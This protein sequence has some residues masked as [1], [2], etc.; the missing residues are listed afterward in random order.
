MIHDVNVRYTSRTE[1][2]P[3]LSSDTPMLYTIAIRRKKMS[4]EEVIEKYF[5]LIETDRFSKYEKDF[6]HKMQM[7]LYEGYQREAYEPEMVSDVQAIINNVNGFSASANGFRISTN[8]IFIH[9]NKSQ[10]EFEYYGSKTQRE[11]GDLIFITSVIYNNRKY[12]EKLTITQ[13]KRST[14]RPKWYFNKKDKNGKYPDKEQVY[15]LARF[16][17]FKGTKGSII[18]M[19]EYSLP[20]YS[21]CL[22]SYG[23]LYKPGDFAFASAKIVE[24]FLGNSKNISIEHILPSTDFYESLMFCPHPLFR[25]RDAKE[26]FYIGHKLCR[27]YFIKPFFPYLIFQNNFLPCIGNSSHSCNVHEFSER[28]LRALIGELTFAYEFSYN[29]PAFQF[30][31]DLMMAIKK[32]AQ[33]E[34]NDKIQNFVD[35]FYLH[36]YGE[37][38]RGE[39]FGEFD[40]EGGGIGVIH[41]SINLGKGE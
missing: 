26:L 20:N 41:T 18:P 40:Y 10:I 31:Q 23:L 17:T 12:F 4:T 8:S 9:G 28:Y 11:L 32:K 6:A 38:Q 27:P 36:V 24:A 15:L 35:S 2:Y 29:R 19:R 22:G 34:R 21:N 37:G 7:G 14:K 33:K 3:K 5:Q 16:P 13:F 1:G 39:G 30:L 25:F